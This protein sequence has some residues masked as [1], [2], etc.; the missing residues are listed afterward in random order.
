MGLT[1][2]S[3]FSLIFQVHWPTLDKLDRGLTDCIIVTIGNQTPPCY[4]D[5]WRRARE[6]FFSDA[7][8]HEPP[9]TVA[10]FCLGSNQKDWK[11]LHRLR[12]MGHCWRDTGDRAG[13]WA[14][15]R[16]GPREYCRNGG[17]A[18]EKRSKVSRRGFLQEISHIHRPGCITLHFCLFYPVY[19]MGMKFLP[20]EVNG[21]I[22]SNFRGAEISPQDFPSMSTLF[23]HTSR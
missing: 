9:A 18:D 5:C 20:T 16:E 10:A 13:R 12:G 3:S 23:R 7:I 21:K 8:C 19:L 11:G 17:L 14:V 6:A 1:Q 2:L 4:Y 22:L 15:P